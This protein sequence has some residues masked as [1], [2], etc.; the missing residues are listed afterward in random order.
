M[1]LVPLSWLAFSTN[2]LT[3]D[4][5]LGLMGFR[6]YPVKYIH[7]LFV[8]LEICM[9][10]PLSSVSGRLKHEHTLRKILPEHQFV[11]LRILMCAHTSTLRAFFHKEAESRKQRHETPRC[12]VGRDFFPLLFLQDYIAVYMLN[13][14]IHFL[15]HL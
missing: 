8:T 3:H 4:C 14:F 6:S 7:I 9:S 1:S 12:V 5:R 2:N 10:I 13:S 11:K 15:F